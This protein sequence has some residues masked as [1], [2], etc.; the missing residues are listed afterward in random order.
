MNSAPFSS[1]NCLAMTGDA[2]LSRSPWII[3]SC[4]MPFWQQAKGSCC[5]KSSQKALV[6]FKGRL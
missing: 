5:S 2:V 1:A 4:A 6:S 3:R